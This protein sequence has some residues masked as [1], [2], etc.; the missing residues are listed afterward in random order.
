[1]LKGSIGLVSIDHTADHTAVVRTAPAQG[2]AA[3]VFAA[4]VFAAHS[5]VEPMLVA[6]N[7]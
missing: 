3:R 5:F 4:R 6:A 7:S 1:M 2:F